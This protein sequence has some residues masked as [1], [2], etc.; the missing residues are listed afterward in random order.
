[1][2]IRSS[3][4]IYFVNDTKVI[5]IDLERSN[6]L[7]LLSSSDV[8]K[9]ELTNSVCRYL[10]FNLSDKSSLVLSDDELVLTIKEGKLI[11]VPCSK[12]NKGTQLYTPYSKNE[13]IVMSI[14]NEEEVKNPS[15]VLIIHNPVLTLDGF[16][17]GG[18]V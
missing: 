4:M 6:K 3:S 1:M 2:T 16:F 7:L 15:K 12:V 5:S 11:Y 9:E 13:L 14:N 8:I 18:G 10:R 17:I